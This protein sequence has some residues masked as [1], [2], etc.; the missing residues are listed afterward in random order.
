[1]P[2]RSRSFSV[3]G[4]EGI[5]AVVYRGYIN[6]VVSSTAHGEIRNQQWL[7]INL[8]V[9]H[10]FEQH[11]EV[12]LVHIRRRQYGFAQVCAGALVVVVLGEHIHLGHGALAGEG[13]NTD[14][15][16]ETKTILLETMTDHFIHPF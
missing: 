15:D 3:V 13:Q 1:M 4:I 11:A 14:A 7:R 2:Q 5:D 12:G 6:D 10:A 8:I 16:Q 9:D